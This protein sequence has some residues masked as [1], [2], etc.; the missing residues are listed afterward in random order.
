MTA[1]C[2]E[3]VVFNVI[4]RAYAP[5]KYA[6][7]L[8]ARD[9][10]CSVP[11]AKAWIAHK[12]APQGQHLFNLMRRCESLEQELLQAVRESRECSKD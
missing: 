8:L 10:E 7:K 4:D 5:L 11:T 9:A 3:A 12:H 2:Y 1:V 6:A